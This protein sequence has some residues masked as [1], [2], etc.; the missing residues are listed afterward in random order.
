MHPRLTELRDYVD[1]QRSALLSGACAL[2]RSR[3]TER[4]APD[5]WSVVELF[6]HLYRVEHSCARVIAKGVAEAREAGHPAE[7]ST[8]SVLGA[9][10]EFKLRDRTEK[11]VAPERAAPTGEWSPEQAFAMLTASRAELHDAIRAADG[12]ALG[13]IHQTHARLGEI[14]LYKWI[15]FVGEH[16]ARH[17]Q[18]AAEI[19]EQLGTAAR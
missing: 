7:V 8:T 17:A 15:L 5:R 16:E 10:D 3:W 11:R 1:A 12:L 4:P 18:Q 6:E 14:D 9:L 13:S 2:P 19:A